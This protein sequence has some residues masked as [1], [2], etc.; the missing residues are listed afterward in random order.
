MD[1][2][3]LGIHFTPFGDLR[4]V[5]TNHHHPTTGYEHEGDG[6]RKGEKTR[7]GKHRSI[8]IGN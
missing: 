4:Q 3:F 2:Y 1:F 6:A 8:N 5:R 7:K